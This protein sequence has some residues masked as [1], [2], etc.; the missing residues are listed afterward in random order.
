MIG[1]KEKKEDRE[2]KTKKRGEEVAGIAYIFTSFNNT[3]VHITDLSGHTL[4]RISGG[5]IT[6]HDRLKANPTVAMFVAKKAAEMAREQG[7][8]SLYVRIRSNTGS[9][10][11]G[12]GAHAAVKSLTREGM[13]VISIVD[14][15]R[16]PRGGPKKK[17]G[18]RGRRV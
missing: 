15:T 8:N 2:E 7:V 11:V 1:E 6:K 17:G 14:T 3:I 4:S 10:G 9:T 13:R 18:K 12:P 5:M 16:V